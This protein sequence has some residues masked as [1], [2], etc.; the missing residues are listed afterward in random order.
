MNTVNYNDPGAITDSTYVGVDRNR[1]VVTSGARDFG[2]FAATTDNNYTSIPYHK[3]TSIRINNHTG[4]LL[5]VRRR[6]NVITVDNFEDQNFTNWT[7]SITFG[8]D[9]EGVSGAK[10]DGSAYTKLTDQIMLSDSEITI[11][12][13]TPD[14][15]TYTTDVFILDEYS[16]LGMGTA[17]FASLNESNSDRNTKY[18]VT[19]KF[20]I[21]DGKYD[22]FYEKDGEAIRKP[23]DQDEDAIFGTNQMVDSIVLIAS[24]KEATI[25]PI[26]YHQKVNYSHEQIGHGG[27][28]VYPCVANSAEYEI[29]NL[30][31]DLMNYSDNT[32]TISISGFYAT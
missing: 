27:S 22:S 9:L 16:R 18:I 8:D 1:L 31:S 29:I 28:F 30:G 24:N 23:L 2:T 10:I 17:G 32:Q 25:D 5:G 19:I 12:I 20:R 14:S 26:V 15:S 7:G 6:H 11:G 3:A 13:R 4:K 21:A